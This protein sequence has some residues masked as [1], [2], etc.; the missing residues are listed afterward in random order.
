MVA[1]YYKGEIGLI[2]FAWNGFVKRYESVLTANADVRSIGVLIGI[3]STI[4]RFIIKLW[5]L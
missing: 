1:I 5:E 2:M 3:N 4:N